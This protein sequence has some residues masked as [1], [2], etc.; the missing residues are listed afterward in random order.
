MARSPL[1]HTTP[2]SS[3]RPGLCQPWTVPWS[4]QTD[5]MGIVFHSLL[6]N[7]RKKTTG[8]F[9]EQSNFSPNRGFHPQASSPPKARVEGANGT[10]AHHRF[11]T[12]Q[13][14]LQD[15]GGMG[16]VIACTRLD[17]M[18]THQCQLFRMLRAEMKWI[19]N[20]TQEIN[21]HQLNHH[22]LKKHKIKYPC[23]KMVKSQ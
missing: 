4:W 18:T 16:H 13:E 2:G 22:P 9:S 5:Q 7:D 8:H 19:I 10:E 17:K 21:V 3:L 14:D 20:K 11:G 23:F 12:G 15:G 6:E 1:T